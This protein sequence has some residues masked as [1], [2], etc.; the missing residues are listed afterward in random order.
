MEPFRF[1]PIIQSRGLVTV[2]VVLLPSMVVVEIYLFYSKALSVIKV[3]EYIV[4]SQEKWQTITRYAKDMNDDNNR[5]CSHGR[6]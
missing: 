2:V 5:F 6:K 3:Y 1:V 4:G